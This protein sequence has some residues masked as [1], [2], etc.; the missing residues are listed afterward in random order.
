VTNVQKTSRTIKLGLLIALMGVFT[1][2]ENRSVASTFK[3]PTDFYCPAGTN[4]N[5]T[6]GM[7]EN[8]S[9]VLGPFPA[10]MVKRC[11]TVKQDKEF[12]EGGMW[13]LA[14]AG[15]IRRIGRC[16]FGTFLNENGACY[17]G[18]QSGLYFGPFTKDQVR[19]CKQNKWGIKCEL[20]KWPEA[21]LLGKV[22][23]KPDKP[24]TGTGKIPGGDI[25]AKLYNYYSSKT[26]YWKVFDEVMGFYGTRSNGCVAFMSSALRQIG[27]YVPKS[28]DSRGENIS[29]V[30]RPFSN[31]LEY[32]LGWIRIT[33]DRQLKKG[34]IV[35]TQD[36]KGWSGYPAHTYMFAGWN[37]YDKSAGIV[38]DNQGFKHTRNVYGYSAGNFTPFKYAL[39][40]P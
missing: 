33:D 38:V 21:I 12:C 4:Y 30:T 36:A 31:Y 1:F 34:D 2:S 24:K 26:N 17:E 3:I 16:P 37:N 39:R 18:D 20:M 23:P 35:F 15:L 27:L 6:Y 10:A 11:M 9:E 28:V 8:S 25:N 32:D 19:I 22:N 14:T 7:C 5:A 40:A 29:L 13:D